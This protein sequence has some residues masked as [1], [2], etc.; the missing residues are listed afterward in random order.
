MRRT[1]LPR[2]RATPRRNEGRVQHGRMKEKV[3]AEPNEEQ[4]RFHASLR[5]LGRCQCGCGRN[6]TDIHHLL[7]RT[8]GKGRRR[9]HWYVIFLNSGCHNGRSDSV[10]GLGSEA[11]FEKVHGVDL[12]AISVAN[13]ERWR[14]TLSESESDSDRVGKDSSVNPIIGI[15]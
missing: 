14:A 4:R 11:A 5:A 7:A 8:P 9:D 15:R 13:L 10:H 6:G 1:P 2:K 3:G 12:V